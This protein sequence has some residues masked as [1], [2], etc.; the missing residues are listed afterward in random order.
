[1]SIFTR[2]GLCYYEDENTVIMK[3]HTGDIEKGR[4]SMLRRGKGGMERFI[5]RYTIRKGIDY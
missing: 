3:L 2:K 4:Q 5:E 1:M